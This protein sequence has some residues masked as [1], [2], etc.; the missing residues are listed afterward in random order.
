MASNLNV[1]LNGAVMQVVQTTD[2]TTRVN[3]S[4]NNPSLPAS[5]ST[6]IDYLPIA[7]GAGTIV[8]LPAATVWVFAMRNLG[9]IN[10]TPAGNISVLIQVAGGALTAIANSPIV[11]PNGVFLYWQQAETAGGIIAVTLVASV[12]NTPAELLMAA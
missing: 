8:P 12:A 4:L 2:S 7:T 5:E 11:L 1:T 3:A 10:S 6:Y 9:G